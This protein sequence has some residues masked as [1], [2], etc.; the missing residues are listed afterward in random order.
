MLARCNGAER[1]KLKILWG[2][3]AVD[4][5]SKVSRRGNTFELNLEGCVSA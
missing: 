1:K 4:G 2:W 3:G 5:A